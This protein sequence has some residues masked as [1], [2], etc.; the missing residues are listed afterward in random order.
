M[1]DFGASAFSTGWPRE[2]RRTTVIETFRRQSPRADCRRNGIRR[3]AGRQIPHFGCSLCTSDGHGF[4]GDCSR[5]LPDRRF[6]CGPFRAN[7]SRPPYASE[8]DLASRDVDRESTCCA[9][10]SAFETGLRPSTCRVS[11]QLLAAPMWDPALTS[12]SFRDHSARKH[13]SVGKGDT[14]GA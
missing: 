2:V 8:R 5:R 1:A 12:R 6:S 13:R 11:R 3:H 14:K 4:P 10:S 9:R 7:N